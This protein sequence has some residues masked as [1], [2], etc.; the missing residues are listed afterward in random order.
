MEVPDLVLVTKGDLGAPARRAAADAARR[1][2]ARRG[3]R[4]PPASPSSRPRPATGIAAALDADRRRAAPRQRRPRR[5]GAARRA[6]PGPSRGSVESFGRVGLA[7]LAPRDLTSRAAPFARA[8]E[9]SERA[10]GRGSR[11]P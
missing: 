9:L 7:A 5:A 6:G 11:K 4:P 10:R 1:A 3:G 8:R 2:L